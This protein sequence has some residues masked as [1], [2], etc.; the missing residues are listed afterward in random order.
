MYSSPHNPETHFTSKGLHKGQAPSEPR[1]FHQ[2]RQKIVFSGVHYMHA[3]STFKAEFFACQDR[4]PVLTAQYLQQLLQPPKPSSLNLHIV[5]HPIVAASSLSPS[6]SKAPE[7][8][9]RPVHSASMLILRSHAPLEE[10]KLCSACTCGGFAKTAH[11][12]QRRHLTKAS[13]FKQLTL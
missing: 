11:R 8:K 7:S 5:L 2:P 9:N 6:Y 4:K 3:T 1:S 12:N 10:H 13:G